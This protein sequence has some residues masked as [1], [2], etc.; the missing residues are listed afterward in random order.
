MTRQTANRAW[1]F[2]RL[3]AAA[4]LLGLVLARVTI[5]PAIQFELG[6]AYETGNFHGWTP[7]FTQDYRKAADWLDA[8]AQAG[9]ARAQ[10]RLG[11]LHAHGWGVSASAAEAVAWFSQSARNGY[12]PACFHLGWMYHTGDGVP[13]DDD[14]AMRL[15]KQAANQGMAAAHLALGRFHE[16][17]EGLS[18]DAAEAIKWYV[19]ALHFAQSR[20]GRFDN[21]AFAE[22]AR[23]ALDKLTARI[24]AS[25]EQGRLLARAWLSSYGGE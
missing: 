14:Q 25:A 22:Q 7:G 2:A 21:A 18:V 17:G 6:Y 9:H 8:A 19:L 1:R 3:V 12:A 11:I 16:Q 10:Y 4:L 23:A 5:W 20:Q 24:P 15:L 13:R